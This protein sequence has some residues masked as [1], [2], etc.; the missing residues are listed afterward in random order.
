[1][2]SGNIE[3][4]GQ[5][6]G[7]G[8]LIDLL[9]LYTCRNLTDGCFLLIYILVRMAY[10]ELEVYL[11]RRVFMPSFE[12]KV[13]GFKYKEPYPSRCTRRICYL[14]GCREVEVPCGL[15]GTQF[16]EVMVSFTFP[17]LDE[18]YETIIFQCANEV[19]YLAS[20]IVG[21]AL[22]SCV[23]IDESCM[24]VVQDSVALA[25][26]VVEKAYHKCLSQLRM[27]EEIIRKSE[28]KVYIRENYM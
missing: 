22:S 7:Y 11:E 8:F 17:D 6:K 21:N 4:A 18:K 1:M 16:Y 26:E 14:K 3:G 12:I 20:G 9:P 5:K 13:W 28:V 10:I 19:T 15:K 2:F 25:N 24:K 27:P 23:E